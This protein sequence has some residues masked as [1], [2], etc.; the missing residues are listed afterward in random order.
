MMNAFSLFSRYKRH[1]EISWNFHRLVSVHTCMS[2]L[3]LNVIDA[4]MDI[5][6]ILS[7]GK[8]IWGWE[9]G[10][11]SPFQKKGG[12]TFFTLVWLLIL[13][14]KFDTSSRDKS[15]Y[16]ACIN[17]DSWIIPRKLTWHWIYLYLCAIRKYLL[18]ELTNIYMTE[19][20]CKWRKQISWQLHWIIS[21]Q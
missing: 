19:F 15:L 13:R 4:F 21:E 14:I 2:W 8:K 10:W 9:V 5:L 1:N 17:A 6:L 20:N 3:L 11:T 18:L 12:W 7:R 16:I